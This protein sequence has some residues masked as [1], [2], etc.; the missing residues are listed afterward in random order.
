MEPRAVRPRVSEAYYQ[1]F[2]KKV[3]GLKPA[4][5]DKLYRSFERSHDQACSA[6]STGENPAP[7][8]VRKNRG[9]HVAVSC[10]QA[11]GIW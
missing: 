10:R 8:R 2:E 3:K 11:D 5:R 9:I 6:P 1:N 7:K 4:Q